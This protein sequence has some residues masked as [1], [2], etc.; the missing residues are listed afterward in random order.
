MNR[1]HPACPAELGTAARGTSAALKGMPEREAAR[2]LLVRSARKQAPVCFLGWGW[3]RVPCACRV[4]IPN[5]PLRYEDD[6][7]GRS[8]RFHNT[9]PPTIHRARR[10]CKAGL[11]TTTRI[12]AGFN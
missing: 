11:G 7:T 4:H 2:P 10:C 8:M 3:S 1:E 6:K 12:S 5:L 9:L